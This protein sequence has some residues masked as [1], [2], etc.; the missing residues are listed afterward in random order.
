[1]NLQITMRKL[2]DREQKKGH[3]CQVQPH[4]DEP[5]G[6]SEAASYEA[7]VLDGV[8]WLCERHFWKVK[9]ELDAQAR[10]TIRPDET[11]H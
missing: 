5:D 2:S 7:R 11:V 9:A 8:S 1:M 10:V 3:T 4:D 6:C